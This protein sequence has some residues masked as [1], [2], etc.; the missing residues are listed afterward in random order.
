MATSGS[1]KTRFGA[2]SAGVAIAITIAPKSPSTG[3]LIIAQARSI[4]RYVFSRIF[5]RVN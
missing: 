4:G 1:E 5:S 2:A 3:E